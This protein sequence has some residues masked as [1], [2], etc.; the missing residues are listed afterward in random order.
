MSFRCYISPVADQGKPRSG[1]DGGRYFAVMLNVGFPLDDPSR[2]TWQLHQH[3]RELGV[4]PVTK[5]LF[6]P[7]VAGPATV[8]RN[9]GSENIAVFGVLGDLDFYWQGSRGFEEEIVAVAG[10]N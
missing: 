2:P 3:Q 6:Y 4:C 9:N 1:N 10:I 5:G 7:G 8:T